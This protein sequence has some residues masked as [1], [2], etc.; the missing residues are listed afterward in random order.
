MNDLDALKA[1]AEESLNYGRYIDALETR[2][3]YLEEQNDGLALAIKMGGK[4]QERLQGVID[5]VDVRLSSWG[6]AHDPYE[7]KQELLHI[8]RDQPVLET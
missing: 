8:V 3:R 6:S 4:E 2:V 7:M 1:E 5:S